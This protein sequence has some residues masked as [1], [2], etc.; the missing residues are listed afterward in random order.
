MVK[1]FA[2]FTPTY[3]RAELLEKIMST[4]KQEA[5]FYGHNVVHIIVDDHSLKDRHIYETLFK[6]YSC[7][8]YTVM[9]HRNPNNNG[10]TKFWKTWN[11]MFRL[12]RKVEWQ[13]G[14]ALPDDCLPCKNFF[15]RIRDQFLLERR[16]DKKEGEVVAMNISVPFLK[17]WG[18]ARFVDGAFICTK[19]FFDLLEWSLFEIPNTNGK[20]AIGSG[21][22]KQMTLRLHKIPKSNISKVNDV[23]YIKPFNV[24]SVMFPVKDYPNR[25]KIWGRNNFIDDL[26]AASDPTVRD[27]RRWQ[28]SV[29]PQKGNRS[30]WW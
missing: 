28:D 15:N 21:V 12:A 10:K 18:F 24:E 7:G 22:G 27:N 4:L 14:V 30:Y 29:P 6:K 20:T 3:E 23:S 5:K 17:N 11:I 13:Y 19:K 25:P 9:Y 2:I 1:D 26:E 16:L 8:Y